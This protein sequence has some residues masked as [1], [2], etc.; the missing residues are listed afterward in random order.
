MTDKKELCIQFGVFLPRSENLGRLE[1]RLSAS[2]D[3][4][5]GEI[6]KYGILRE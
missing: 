6:L 2:R 3:G 4:L 5:L 1:K